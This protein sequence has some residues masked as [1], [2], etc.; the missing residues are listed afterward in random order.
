[1]EKAK[2]G[3][4]YDTLTVSHTSVDGG[5]KLRRGA[6]E[7]C[8]AGLVKVFLRSIAAVWLVSLSVSYVETGY[9]DVGSA[10]CTP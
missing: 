6:A 9:D 5:S 1:M 2:M 3:S 10:P 4:I 8:S 7:I